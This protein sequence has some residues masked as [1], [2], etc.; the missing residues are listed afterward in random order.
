M[1]TRA[2]ETFAGDEK[3]GGVARR[4]FKCS[5]RTPA[6]WIKGVILSW[7]AGE[8]PDR[9]PA[10]VLKKVEGVDSVESRFVPN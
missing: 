5:T 10:C 4:V 9:M 6:R 1:N 8:P 2:R 7:L 3:P